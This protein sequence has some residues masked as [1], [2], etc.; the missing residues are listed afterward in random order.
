MRRPWPTVYVRT[1][2]LRN[3][4]SLSIWKCNSRTMRGT[5]S[6]T[7]RQQGSRSRITLRPCHRRILPS[8][9]ETLEYTPRCKI[10][11]ATCQVTLSLHLTCV[12]EIGLCPQKRKYR[13]DQKTGT[14]HNFCDNFDKCSPIFII[15]SPSDSLV[16]LQQSQ[17]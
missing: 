16:N 11:A 2:S 10:R 6:K 5:V 12:W 8:Q 13:V 4:S 1:N 17:Y 14:R 3:S 9:P 15:L 7:R